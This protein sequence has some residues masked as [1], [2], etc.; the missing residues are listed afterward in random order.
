MKTVISFCLLL[1]TLLCEAQNVGIGTATPTEPLTVNGS[2]LIDCNNQNTGSYLGQGLLKFGAM[3]GTAIG[4]NKSA[5]ISRNG[6]DFYTN[7]LVRM[8]I[9]STGNVRLSG[10][11][12]IATATP[13]LLTYK[14][15]VNGS[16]RARLDAYVN[17]DAWVDRN[18]DVDGTS[19]LYGNIIAGN[20][21]SVGGDV[22]VAGN[23][24]VKNNKGLI[25]STN[26]T[27]QVVAYPSGVVGYTN[28][29]SGY[30]DDVEFALPDVF[31]SAPRICIANVTEQTG[32]YERWTFTVHS[33]NVNTNRF[34]VR[35]YNASNVSSTMQVRLNF[36]AIG[37]AP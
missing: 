20:D 37:A 1:T 34:W 18:L 16:L 5:G 36:I 9:D 26:G 21:I 22:T 31:A 7:S 8:I 13:D 11:L 12:G 10:G 28:A 29:P 35:F 3:G 25:R 19:N 6:I 32:T 27:Q 23:L 14:L 33:I 30:T 17:R 15:D 4:S 2:Q 24:L